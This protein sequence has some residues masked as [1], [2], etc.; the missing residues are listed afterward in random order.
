MSLSQRLR[1]LEQRARQDGLLTGEPACQSCG[2]PY[3]LCDRIVVVSCGKGESLQHCPT[4]GRR[5]D[6]E[7][8]DIGKDGGVIFLHP[9][10]VDAPLPGSRP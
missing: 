8:R 4:C 9:G 3:P 2:G 1:A 7:G 6:A 10:R 5:V